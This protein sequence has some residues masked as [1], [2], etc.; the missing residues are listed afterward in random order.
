[1]S[2]TTKPW[3]TMKRMLTVWLVRFF[4]TMDVLRIKYI[5]GS[6]DNHQLLEER[7]CWQL[8]GY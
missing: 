8:A 1:M 7:G 4:K 5:L 2:K 6:K 3:M